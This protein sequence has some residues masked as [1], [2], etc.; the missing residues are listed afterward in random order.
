M[1]CIFTT[2]AIFVLFL[3][4]A[5]HTAQRNSD[6]NDYDLQSVSSSS[7]SFMGCPRRVCWT[8]P[9]LSDEELAVLDEVLGGR[10]SLNTFL[11]ESFETSVW[12]QPRSNPD[13]LRR[14]SIRLTLTAFFLALTTPTTSC[15]DEPTTATTLPSSLSGGR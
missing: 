6:K 5:S 13:L 3:L 4:I 12:N 2:S 9:A 15:G 10:N 8:D 1:Q 7:S 14:S 11:T